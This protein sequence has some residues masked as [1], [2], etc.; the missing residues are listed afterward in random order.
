MDTRTINNL[1]SFVAMALT[2][3]NEDMAIKAA[4]GLDIPEEIKQHIIY[5]IMAC[6][7]HQSF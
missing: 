5:V 2:E 3:G 1:I 6:Y 7:S 4:E